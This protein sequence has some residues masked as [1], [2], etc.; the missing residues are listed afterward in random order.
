MPTSVLASILW[1]ALLAQPA[2]PKQPVRPEVTAEQVR[3]AI[4]NGVRFLKD[5]QDKVRGNWTERAAQPGGI[6]ALCTLALIEAG[7]PLQSPAMQK[8]LAYLRALGD[9]HTTY[10]TA[11]QTMVFCAAEPKKDLLLIRRNVQWL[12]GAQITGDERAGAWTYYNRVGPQTRGDNSNS[13]FAVLAL[14]E[15]EQ[16]GVKVSEPV[17]QRTLQYWL[18]CQRTDGSWAYY[19]QHQDDKQTIQG[20]EPSGSMTCA[21]ISALVIA[22]GRLSEGDAQVTGGTVKCCCAQQDLNNL[23]RALQWL[24]SRFSVRAN[25]SVSSGGVMHSRG[26]LYYYL[27]G[28]ERIGR[29]TGR[30]FIGKHDWYRAGAQMFVEAQDSLRGFWSGT[31]Y[32]EDDP[33]IATSFALLF[34]AKGRRPVVMAKLRYGH[35]SDWDR[36]RQGVQNLAHHVERRLQQKL[37]W[38][39]IDA[40]AATVDDLLETPVLVL[41]GHN[42][43]TLTKEQKANLREYIQQGGFVLAEACCAGQGFDRGFRQL[44]AELFPSSPLRL[45]PSDHAIWYAEQKVNPKYLRP[46]YGIDACCRTS[47]VYCPQDLSCYWE[48]SRGDRETGYPPAVQ[49]EIAACLA[50]GA[51]VI[52]YATNRQLKDKLDVSPAALRAKPADVTRST[53]EVA[54]VSHSGGS[55]E[56]ANA[57]PNLLQL[58]E[59]QLRL[60][61]NGKPR[62]VSPGDPQLLEH[63]LAFI[64]GRRDFQWSAA[65]RKALAEYLQRG[66]FLFGDAI[67]ASPQFAAAFRREVQAAL[68]RARFRRIPADHP[69]FSK[70]FR[71]YDLATVTLRDPQV[72]AENDPLKAKL[73]RIKPLLEGV[74]IDGRLVVVFSPYD[75]SCAMENHAS[76]ECKGYIKGDAARIA[77]NVILYALQQ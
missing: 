21:G 38:Q 4:Q 29:L 58:A 32:A 37:T 43:P 33:V 71:G 27:Y 60:P 63:P 52:T 41:S 62:T 67:C 34:L 17:W 5:Q 25:P 8:A 51:N 26:G 3:Q 59:S 53:L 6:T 65:E 66:G 49:E 48:L 55:A 12:E 39:T 14:H 16:V 50:I 20:N 74:E 35:D 36:H 75:I 24:G 57:L 45:L 54:V 76:L 15:A 1:A 23:E 68:P 10:G 72:R 42:E 9:P 70:E 18:S 7:E 31:G 28:V 22:A 30:R 61:V 46:L 56:A 19:K 13:Q 77:L 73:E 44:M 69:L 47:V 11:L 40:H 2:P 64:H